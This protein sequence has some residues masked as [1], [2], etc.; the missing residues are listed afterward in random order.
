MPGIK[1]ERAPVTVSGAPHES[2]PIVKPTSLDDAASKVSRALGGLGNDVTVRA[3][4]DEEDVLVSF[5]AEKRAT[6]DKMLVFMGAQPES[7]NPG[8]SGYY[9]LG[10]YRIDLDAMGAVKPAS[11]FEE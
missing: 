7:N 4:A 1:R 5:P 2:V 8:T 11:N 6:V 10:N 9:Q 3:R